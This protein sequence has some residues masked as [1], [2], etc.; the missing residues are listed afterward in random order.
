M[1]VLVR[2]EFVFL[3]SSRP[4][5]VTMTAKRVAIV[6][7]GNSSL[8]A[9]YMSSLSIDIRFARCGVPHTCDEVEG[10]ILSHFF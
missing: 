2:G 1:C 8:L 7:T 5:T 3:V 9:T 4:P 6:R 10:N